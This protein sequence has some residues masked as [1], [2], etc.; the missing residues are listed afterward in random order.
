[1]CV[2]SRDSILSV[3][4]ASPVDS[5]LSLIPYRRIVILN[6]SGAVFFFPWTIKLIHI[7]SLLSN[8]NEYLAVYSS[9]VVVPK[10]RIR[11][12]QTCIALFRILGLLFAVR[13]KYISS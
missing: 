11:V 12:L 9:I 6:R 2:D 13:R 3:S 4:H 10:I 7:V 8:D 5:A 1:M